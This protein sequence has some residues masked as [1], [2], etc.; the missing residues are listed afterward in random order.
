VKVEALA[1][2]TSMRDLDLASQAINLF[3]GFGWPLDSLR[4]LVP[5]FGSA[6]PWHRELSMTHAAGIP[7]NNL[8][9]FDHICLFNLDVPERRIGSNSVVKAA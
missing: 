4:Y 8:W 7:I 2:G 5:V 9:A 3:P 1:F 6:T